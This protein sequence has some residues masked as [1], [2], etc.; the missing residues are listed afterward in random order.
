GDL[1]VAFKDAGNWARAE[2][3]YGR[4]IDLCRAQDDHTNL[5]RWLQN[6][7]VMLLEAGDPQHARRFFEDGL[8]AAARSGNTY[9]IS[10]GHGNLGVLQVNEGDLVGAIDSFEKALQISPKESL[11]IQWRQYLFDTLAQWG[12]SLV[13]AGEI[14]AAIAAHERLIAACDK[15]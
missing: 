15:Y 3:N 10:C 5:S 13:E 1:A 7:G 12:T 4:A 14:G 6:T 9:Q 8:A 11:T 2:V